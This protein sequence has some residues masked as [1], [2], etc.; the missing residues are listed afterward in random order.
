MS[1]SDN[2][3]SRGMPVFL[4]TVERGLADPAAATVETWHPGDAVS[5]KL[6]ACTEPLRDVEHLLQEL[7]VEQRSRRLKILATPVSSFRLAVIQLGDYL[8]SAPDLKVKLTNESRRQVA[9]LV[10]KLKANDPAHEAVK[11][12]RDKLSAH[13][14]KNIS[15]WDAE[16]RLR[17]CSALAVG[18]AL[19]SSICTLLRLL[20][21]NVY[22]WFA[23][24]TP[25]GFLRLMS[26][27]P[28][29]TTFRVENQHIVEIIKL[30]LAKSPRYAVSGL[31][32]EV[33]RLSHWMFESAEDRTTQRP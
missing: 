31:C 11:T 7:P 10:E 21:L 17:D 1:E 3:A 6:W 16:R 13:I 8:S 19:H 30:E 28:Y 14:D 29:L 15:S 9:K 22:S 12:V 4:S 20:E 5:Q 23:E 33:V 26:A 27:E 32:E 18:T 2:Q 25:E 24:D